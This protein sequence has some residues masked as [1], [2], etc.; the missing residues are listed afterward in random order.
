MWYP[1]SLAAVAAGSDAVTRAQAQT[2]LGIT[3]ANDLADQLIATAR[4]FVENYCGIVTIG[5]AATIKCDAFCDLARLPVAP[6]RSITSIAYVDQDGADQTLATSVYELR[7]DGLIASVVLKYNQVWPAIRPGSRITIVAAA[8]YADAASIPAEIKSA[9]LLLISKQN[10]LSRA[11]PL[12]R[13]RAIEGVGSRQW[14][15]S[16]QPLDRVDRAA[17]DL[18][19]NFRC[20]PS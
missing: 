6:V 5:R 12:L 17:F 19:E 4:G 11:D 10:A 3:L 18:L 13:G 7:S 9:I 8:G 1:A 20:F 14:D 16:G 2:Q 15:T